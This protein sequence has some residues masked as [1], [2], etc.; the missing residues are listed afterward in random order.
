MSIYVEI[1]LLLRYSLASTILCFRLLAL[2]FGVKQTRVSADVPCFLLVLHPPSVFIQD[3]H[4]KCSCIILAVAIISLCEQGGTGIPV[5][6]SPTLTTTTP[7]VTSS[8]VPVPI[9]NREPASC[10]W[11]PAPSQHHLPTQVGSELCV[12]LR[13]LAAPPLTAP[14]STQS[15]NRG[16][17]GTSWQA[18]INVSSPF[19]FRRRLS[20]I[21]TRHLERR[22]QLYIIHTQT[23]PQPLV[24][25]RY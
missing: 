10:H 11:L 3:G 23:M 2:Q 14:D 17:Y 19:I 18:G 20:L 13:K 9:S 12:Y 25:P 5:S 15:K 4:G 16:N 6:L 7:I 22:S 21:V 24:Y 8:H 1:S